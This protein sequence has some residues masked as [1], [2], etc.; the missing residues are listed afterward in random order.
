MADWFAQSFKADVKKQVAEI[1]RSTRAE[2]VVAVRPASGH[3]RHVDA[4]VG[5]AF[6]LLVL[7]VFLYHPARFEFTYLPLELAGSFVLGTVLSVV[8]P[9]GRWLTPRRALDSAVDL[10]ASA[11]FTDC[12][13]Y[14][15][16]GRSGVLLFVSVYERRFRVRADQGVPIAE[17]A[18]WKAVC[19]RFDV[20]VAASDR[21]KFVNALS[22][23]GP[24]LAQLLPRSADDVNELGDDVTEAA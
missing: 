20:A 17:I 19:Q 21:E 22:E 24:L 13:V 10:A 15:T 5:A 8:T 16:R 14:R 12:G 3:Y 4:Y 18:D 6:A 11:A 2:I 23:L 1:E 9:I 7:C